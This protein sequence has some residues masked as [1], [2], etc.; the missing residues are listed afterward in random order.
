M[1]NRNKILREGKEQWLNGM[2]RMSKQMMRILKEEGKG[3]LK[4]KS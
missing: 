3:G 2:L 4:E 1:W